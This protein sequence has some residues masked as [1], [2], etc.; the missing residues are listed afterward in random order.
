MKRS[1]PKIH[2]KSKQNLTNQIM[3]TNNTKNTLSKR[4]IDDDYIELDK[5]LSMEETI[6]E[7]R[8][9]ERILN[10]KRKE[11][12]KYELDEVRGFFEIK[13][14]WEICSVDDDE[15]NITLST[16]AL[17]KEVKDDIIISKSEII[18]RINLSNGVLTNENIRDTISYILKSS[19]Y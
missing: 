6:E 13:V 12:E 9:R 5:L 14:G 17:G 3:S 1:V 19:Y 16:Y 8:E 18:E 15:I 7:K 11:L 2:L 4:L 10:I